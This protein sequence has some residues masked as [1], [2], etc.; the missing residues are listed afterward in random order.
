MKVDETDVL[1]GYFQR[2]TPRCIRPTLRAVNRL[3]QNHIF[4]I[5]DSIQ[6]NF[7]LRYNMW[8]NIKLYIYLANRRKKLE[9]AGFQIVPRKL[10]GEDEGL[11][12]ESYLKP[13]IAV[14]IPYWEKDSG[15][16]L[17]GEF[18]SE[19]HLSA[20]EI[21]G[22]ENVKSIA[23]L[24]DDWIESCVNQVLAFGST[25]LLIYVEQDPVKSKW[26]SLDVFFFNLRSRGWV[27]K[28]VLI[29]YDSVWDSTKFRIDAITKLIDN[30]T[31]VCIDRSFP[32][33]DRA[34]VKYLGPVVLPFSSC[35]VEQVSAI[36]RRY[37]PEMYVPTFFGSQYEYR[38]KLLS[39]I[40]VNREDAI[41][42]NPQGHNATYH[43]YLSSLRRYGCTIDFSRAS[44]RRV[45]QFKCRIIESALVGSVIITDNPKGASSIL[46]ELSILNFWS[47]ST[48]L[49]RTQNV[50]RIE[51]AWSKNNSDEILSGV[52]DKAKYSF[53]RELDLY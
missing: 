8:Y 27:G 4:R 30:V 38:K 42:I 40:S 31:V 29:A 10:E 45:K 1:T 15:V 28:I 49:R 50:S 5:F 44:A 16:P 53:W 47:A 22:K 24:M 20:I 39:K 7:P 17:S 35:S 2:I 3:L 41:L 18:F 11:T 14:V 46:P 6:A 36:R 9:N 25:H 19:L 37:Q 33:T 23:N 26:W 32:R 48:L 52:I 43:E 34:G 12:N 21:F 13:R 51:R